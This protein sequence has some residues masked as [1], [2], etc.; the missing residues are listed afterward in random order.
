M[1]RKRAGGNSV[2]NLERW[3]GTVDQRLDG[4]DATI[5]EGNSRQEDALARLE[6]SLERFIS[7]IEE[8]RDKDNREMDA[9]VR[10]L[11]DFRT[12]ARAKVALVSGVVGLVS[13]SAGAVLLQYLLKGLGN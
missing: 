9:R 12:S 1:P 4:I 8:R 3:R 7:R 10:S 11:E 6:G 13:G 5:R 2:D